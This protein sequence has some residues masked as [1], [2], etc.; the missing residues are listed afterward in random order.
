MFIRN[1]RLIQLSLAL[2]AGLFFIQSEVFAQK[3]SEEEIKQIQSAKVA[4]ITNRLDLTPEESA[5]FWPVYNEFSEKKRVLN[6]QQRK[7]I[8]EKR[9]AGTTDEA[10]LNNLSEIQ[11]IKQKQLDLEKEYQEK[12]LKVISASQIA[13]LYKAEANFNEMLLQ[14]LRQNRGN[15][16]K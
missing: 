11:D 5:N 3:R 7:I 14:R 10:V 12:F 15:D 16:P 9:E 8:H 13:E 6:R 2:F 1:K 4:M